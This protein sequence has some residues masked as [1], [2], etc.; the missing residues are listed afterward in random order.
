MLAIKIKTQNDAFV[1]DPRP[2]LARILR[3]LAARIEEESLKEWE[4]MVQ[5]RNGNTCGSVK[6]SK[7]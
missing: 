3:D 1:G 7:R 2:E 4:G 5:D 6:V